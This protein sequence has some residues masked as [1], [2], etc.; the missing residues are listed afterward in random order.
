MQSS[1]KKNMRTPRQG[2]A[3]KPFI[4]SSRRSERKQSNSPSVQNVDLRGRYER[5]LALAEAAKTT[6]DA[7]EVENY[8]Q[9]AEHYGRLMREQGLQTIR[10]DR[11]A[12]SDSAGGHR[13]PVDRVDSEQI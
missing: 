1:V 4:P 10:T 11:K 6:G 9:H 2:S 5:Y 7:V 12:R 8:Y 13:D 3:P